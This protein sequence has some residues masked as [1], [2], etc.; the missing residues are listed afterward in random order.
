MSNMEWFVDFF[1]SKGGIS[2]FQGNA[3]LGEIES[4][5]ME[6]LE[7]GEDLYENPAYC[8]TKS[9]GK[10]QFVLM[11]KMYMLRKKIYWWDGNI[12]TWPQSE[13]K[14]IYETKNARI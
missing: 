4:W 10:K 12:R 7:I 8:A 5:K 9:K 11:K 3:W 14:I 6:Y 1:V 2:I 13:F